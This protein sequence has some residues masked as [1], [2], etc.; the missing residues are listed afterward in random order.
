M[1]SKDPQNADDITKHQEG[2][3]GTRSV[4]L[5]DSNPHENDPLPQN[6]TVLDLNAIK[7]RNSS[8]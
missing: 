4:K 1:N 5:L 7:V 8:S 2:D 3:R 6:P